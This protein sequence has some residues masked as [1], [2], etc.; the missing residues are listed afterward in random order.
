MVTMDDKAL[1]VDTIV[2]VYANVVETPFHE[3]ALATINAAH[4]AGWTI[5]IN[6]QV[7]LEYQAACRS[8]DMG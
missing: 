5:W 6:R 1:F 2:L 4:E 8:V 3:R 7:I